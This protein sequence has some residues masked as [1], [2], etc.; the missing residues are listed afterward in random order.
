MG[1][2]YLFCC[3]VFFDGVGSA[4]PHFLDMAFLMWSDGDE[5]TFGLHNSQ[6]GNVNM[7]LMTVLHTIGI[8][9]M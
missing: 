1:G 3:G 4:S 6:K 9:I 7:C 2:Y 8:S 5:M